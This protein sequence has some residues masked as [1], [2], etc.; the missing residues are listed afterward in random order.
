MTEEQ[1]DPDQLLQ[2]IQEEEKKAQSGRLKIFFGMS[3]GVGKTYTMLVQAHDRVKEGVDVVVGTVNTHG[4][5]ETEK[6]LEGLVVVPEK[7]VEFKDKAFQEFDLEEILKRQ[8][9]LVL[10]D[11]L[12]HTNVPGSRHLKRWQDVVDI[13]D[14]GIDVYT[15]LNVQHLESRKDLVESITGISIHETVPDLVLERASSIEIIDITPNDL[16]QR[17]KEGKVYLGDQSIIAAQNFFQEGHLTALREIALRFTAEKVDHDLHSI[18]ALG[19]GW[20]VRERLM[21]AVSP[22]PSSLQLIRS[23]RRLAFEL[24]APW[25]AVYVDTGVKLDSENQARLNKHLQLGK[26]LGAEVIIVNDLD[27]ANALQ[28]IG[29][30]KNIT[31]L[32]IGRPSKSSFFQFFFQK[33]LI[34]RLE[35]ENKSMDILILREDKLTGI[36]RRTIPP[37]HIS[38]P[39]LPYWVVAGAAI[40]MNI[41]GHFLVPLFDYTVVGYF[42]LMEILA[43]SLFVGQIPLFL[44]AIFSALSWYFFFIPPIF[45]FTAKD[46]TDNFLVLMFFFTAIIVGTLNTRMRKKDL[47]LYQ[48]EEKM[49]HLYEV[50]QEITK[51]TNVH[52]LQM[53]VSLKLHTLFG[54]EFAIMIRGEDGQLIFEAK[55]EQKSQETD[56]AAALW[57]LRSGKVSGWSTDTLPSA[58]ALY[59]PIRFSKKSLGVLSYYSKEKKPLS[60]GEVR[61]LETICEQLGIYLER[62]VFEARV[63]AQNYT[64]QVEK[65]YTSLIGALSKGFYTP[66]ENILSLNKKIHQKVYEGKIDDETKKLTTTMD[67]SGKDLKILV[68]NTLIFSQLDSG[69]IPFDKQKYSIQQLIDESLEETK[70]LI[71]SHPIQIDIPKSNLF[72]TFDFPL[73][74]IA[75]KNLLIN[76]MQYSATG[77]II[78]IIYKEG[79]ETFTLSITD[80]GPGI[81]KEQIPLIFE[82]FTR[83]PG[84]PSERLGIGL[85]IVKSIVDLHQGKLEIKNRVKIGTECSITLPKE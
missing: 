5:L 10:I 52:F 9:Q 44:A 20:K 78:G 42:F 25:I 12:A 61:L 72:F 47:F 71:N 16:L 48:K 39:S 59:F 66:L 85:T 60:S 14:A 27:V 37:F 54:G 81:P 30:Q 40:A 84:A 58:E 79:E 29:R 13:L 75:L 77:K 32:V 4:R 80:E 57:C 64:R 22:A 36:Y 56:L 24:D 18:L 69:F 17:L 35:K 73:M 19:K 70:T 49:E 26:E 2:A 6:M 34:D 83:L 28:S 31:R 1:P 15:T 65:L 21:V 38:F 41:L 51:S 7:W 3:A 62:Y 8:P 23:A 33:S 53:N 82:K 68:N 55:Q 46:Q 43:L 50:M 45:T 76:A 67:R 63:Q 74:K 11:E